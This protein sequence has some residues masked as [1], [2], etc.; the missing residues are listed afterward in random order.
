MVVY[1]PIKF[2]HNKINIRKKYESES[3]FIFIELGQ[4]PNQ[5][6][7]KESIDNSKR[8]SFCLFPQE[9]YSINQLEV[10]CARLPILVH[11]NIRQ[12]DSDF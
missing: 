7:R 12:S 10:E 11:S 1:V 9:S 3:V 2:V 6:N 8:D 4:G 5:N